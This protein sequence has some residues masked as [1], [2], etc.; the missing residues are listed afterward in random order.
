MG[1]I[2]YVMKFSMLCYI[3]LY[4]NYAIHNDNVFCTSLFPASRPVPSA[5]LEDRDPRLWDQI[6]RRALD[7]APVA[8]PSPPLFGP[9]ARVQLPDVGGGCMLL[10]HDMHG[11]LFPFAVFPC[12][13]RIY[14]VGPTRTPHRR[15]ASLCHFE[16]GD[17]KGTP[18]APLHSFL[19]QWADGS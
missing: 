12:V 4:L 16:E 7:Q 11:G 8:P 3:I 14:T 5:T 10:I 2:I 15:T 17:G 18:S 19:G 9:P 1:C 13:S 6:Q